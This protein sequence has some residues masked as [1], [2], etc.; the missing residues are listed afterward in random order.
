MQDE[1]Q[2]QLEGMRRELT[3]LERDLAERDREAADLSAALA[4]ERAKLGNSGATPYTNGSSHGAVHGSVTVRL[5]TGCH[6]TAL[7]RSTRQHHCTGRLCCFTPGVI[8]TSHI[9]M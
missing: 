6:Q 9:D 4:N 1:L 3:D 2:Q 8:C 5:G 7:R